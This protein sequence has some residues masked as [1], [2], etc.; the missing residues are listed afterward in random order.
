MSGLGERWFTAPA[1]VVNGLYFPNYSITDAAPD[2]GDSAITET[3]GVGGFAMAAAPA[4]VKFVGGGA[5][6]ALANTLAMTHITL[7]R[8]GAFTLPALDF[9]GTPAGID[10]RR[11]VERATPFGYMEVYSSSYLHFAPGLSDNAAF[12]LKKMP[13]NAYLGMYLDSEG[14]SGIIKDLPDDETAYFEY[15]PMYYPY[16]L[17]K[18]PETGAP[19]E[20]PRQL[21][22][23]V[24]TCIARPELKYPGGSPEKALAVASEFYDLMARR[25]FVPNSPTLMNA[26]REMGMLS[27]CFVLPVEDSIEGIFNSI[28]ATALIQKAGGGTGFSFSRLRPRGDVVRSSG[29]TT[30][31]PLSFIQVFSK[32]TDAIA[33]AVSESTG[34]VRIF[35]DGKVVLRIEP[36]ERGMKWT[37]F[38]TEPPKDD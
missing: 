26:G 17:K 19:V 2:L 36:M 13:R 1:P 28:K 23:R 35:Q 27:A 25:R 32:A 31:G 29:G 14:P 21:Y 38:E 7:R 5:Q 24:A 12:N 34:T 20:T 11:V 6:D 18:D 9:A 33:I 4:I 30:E 22:W 8:N 16:V 10:A 15:L 3:A 37:E